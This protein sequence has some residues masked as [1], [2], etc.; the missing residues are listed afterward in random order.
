[1][2]QQKQD[3][4]KTKRFPLG[5][6]HFPLNHDSS[7]KGNVWPPSQHVMLSWTPPSRTQEQKQERRQRQE[8]QEEGE[9]EEERE[10]EEEAAE[11][12]GGGGEK[13]REEEV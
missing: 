8:L 6:G 3:A 1:M 10:R 11:A 12:G 5:W 9:G 7:R 2:V 13:K 4:L